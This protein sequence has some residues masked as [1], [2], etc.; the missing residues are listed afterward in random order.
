MNRY[1]SVFRKLI[2]LPEWLINDCVALHCTPLIG[3]EDI[4]TMF[5]N[6]TTFII[7]AVCVQLI[8][9]QFFGLRIVNSTRNFSLQTHIRSLPTHTHTIELMIAIKWTYE[10]TKWIFHNKFAFAKLLHTGN[11]PNAEKINFRWGQVSDTLQLINFQCTYDLLEEFLN[12]LLLTNWQRASVWYQAKMNARLLTR[13]QGRKKLFFSKRK[14][15]VFQCENV[16]GRKRTTRCQ[17]CC[18]HSYHISKYQKIC[19]DHGDSYILVG[20]HVDNDQFVFK[21]LPD[22][23]TTDLFSSV[24]RGEKS[25]KKKTK[26]YFRWNL[27]NIWSLSMSELW[28][29]NCTAFA[30]LYFW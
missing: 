21:H 4:Q 18:S 26:D 11:T 17:K 29:H 24:P 14:F 7:S 22:Q 10:M 5:G 13:S 16:R 15:H 2:I 30:D 20:V 8:G 9:F 23:L 12:M 6:F 27:L 19:I 28:L 1:Y 25:R 3:D